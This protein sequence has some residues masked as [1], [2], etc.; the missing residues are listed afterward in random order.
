MTKAAGIYNGEKT[1]S[2][3]NGAGETVQWHV[4]GIRIFSYIIH[5][6]KLKMD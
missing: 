3:A 4:K 2:L 6:N 1:A 5:K